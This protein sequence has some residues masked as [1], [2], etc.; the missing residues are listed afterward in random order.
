VSNG[1]AR[2]SL[3]PAAPLHVRQV[4][5][6]PIT[7][8]REACGPP[9]PRVSARGSAAQRSRGRQAAGPAAPAAAGSRV[10]QREVP[11]V[12]SGHVSSFPPY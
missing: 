6:H 12:L 8:A 4:L 10:R 9:G 3:P 7:V 11:P 2:V 5:V 1:R